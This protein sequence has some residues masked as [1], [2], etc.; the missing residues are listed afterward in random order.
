MQKKSKS[1]RQAI[2]AGKTHSLFFFL[3]SLNVGQKNKA[4]SIKSY[5]I[6]YTPYLSF[7]NP[8]GSRFPIKRLTR[9]IK[10]KIC[11]FFMHV[12]T[13]DQWLFNLNFICVKRF[14]FVFQIDYIIIGTKTAVFF[15][16]LVGMISTKAAQINA[17]KKN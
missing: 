14:F 9:K 11:L 7:H 4:T 15:D 6:R 16:F 13:M 17:M 1:D 3:I 5:H 8:F 12:H 10:Q 2:V